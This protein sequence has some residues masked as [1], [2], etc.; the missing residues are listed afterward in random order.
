MSYPNSFYARTR[1]AGPD[2]P[3]LEGE[4]EA[5]VC[6]VSGGLAGLNTALALGQRGISVILLEARSVG[7]GASGRNGGFVGRGY[8]Q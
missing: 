2:R 5:E 4:H 6:I 8:S 1:T 3:P 7:F